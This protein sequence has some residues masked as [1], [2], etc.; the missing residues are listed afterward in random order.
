MRGI[1]SELA[2]STMDQLQESV[3]WFELALDRLR[4][5][6]RRPIDPALPREQQMKERARRQR[7]LAYR[8]FFSDAIQFALTELD[9]ELKAAENIK[10]SSKESAE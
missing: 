3:D 7:H 5:K 6:Y 8:G 2:Q 10:E 1:Q 9:T 4:R